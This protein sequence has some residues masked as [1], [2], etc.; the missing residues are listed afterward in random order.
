MLVAGEAS[1]DLHGATLARALRA[2]QPAISLAGM[3][4]PRMAA[5]GVRLLATID[6]TGVVGGTEV[7]RRLP[8]LLRR[9]LLLRRRLARWRPRAL[10]LIDF[11]DFNLRLAPRARRLG[12]PVLYFL[13]PQVWAWRPGR[14]R[15]MARDV[16]RVLAV[17]PFEVALYQEAGVPVEFVGHPILDVLPPYD[18]AQARTGLARPDEPLLGLLPGSREAEIRRHLD[19]LLK[20]ARLV[21]AEE[22]RARLAVARAPTVSRTAIE[23]RVA[24]SG[25][26]VAVLHGEA[27]RLM[28]AADLVLTASG[29]ATL[30]AACYGTPMVVLYR[31]S[32]P[33]YLL[34]RLLVRGVGHVSLPNILAGREVVPELLQARA[35]PGRL[36][37]AALT[38]LHDGATRQAQTSA[39][40]EVRGRL[41]PAGAGERAARAVLRALGGQDGAA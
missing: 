9:F 12:I 38:L 2:L 14:L 35:T 29:T 28:A 6:R 18:R 37:R 31:L 5:A 3:G 26:E 11:P 16:G 22:P 21:R 34:A 39:L 19:L 20:A 8:G 27:H 1:G 36:A 33:T 41:G 40:A 15:Q 32:W 4:G 13:A 10:V 25:L 23:G 7:L 30:E 17:F 24:A